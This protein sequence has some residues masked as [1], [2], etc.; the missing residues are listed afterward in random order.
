MS[1]LRRVVFLP[2]DFT[3]VPF[4][5]FSWIAQVTLSGTLLSSVF[6]LAEFAPVA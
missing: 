2:I 6:L 1:M 5:W 4:L 3:V